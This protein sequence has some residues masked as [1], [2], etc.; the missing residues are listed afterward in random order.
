MSERFQETKKYGVSV[1]VEI[2]EL[3]TYNNMQVTG[4]IYWNV[5][6]DLDGLAEV[7]RMLERIERAVKPDPERVL[8][9]HIPNL[10]DM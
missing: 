3:D 4:I 2:G 9:R 8:A 10:D 5:K 6:A 7:G 1:K